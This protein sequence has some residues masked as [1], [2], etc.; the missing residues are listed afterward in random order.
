MAK[1]TDSYTLQIT[2]IQHGNAQIVIDS[3]VFP[4]EVEAN[5]PFDISYD[6]RNDGAE[7]T[8]MGHILEG[9]LQ[10]PGSAWEEAFTEGEIKTK[11]FVHSG[12]SAD[13]SFTI[14]VGHV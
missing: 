12:I 11:S 1:I 13:A 7:D 6:V 2:V 14:E 9:V 10:V 8:L 4:S 3:V 5:T